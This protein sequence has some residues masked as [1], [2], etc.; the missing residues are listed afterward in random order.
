LGADRAITTMTTDPPELQA[1]SRL[2]IGVLAAPD[3]PLPQLLFDSL[4]AIFPVR[5]QPTETPDERSLDGALLVGRAVPTSADCDLPTLLVPAPSDRTGESLALSL[6]DDTRLARPLRGRGVLEDSVASHVNH[7]GSE[8]KRILATVG[9]NAVWWQSHPGERSLSVSAYPLAAPLE[10]EALRDHLRVGR[11][12]GLLPL[13]HFL[14]EQLGTRGWSPPALR[15]S[16]VIDDPNLHWHSY[17]FLK[18]P[19]LI[20]HASRHGYHVG[21][22]TVPLDGWLVNPRAASLIRENPSALSLLMHGND[23][24]SRELGRLSTEAEAERAIAQALRRVAALERRSGVRVERVMA[25]PHGACSEAALDAMF[26]LGIEAACVSR[27]YPWLD[28]LPVPTPLA[29]WDPAEIVGGGLPILPRYHLENPRED[30]VFRA[31]LGQPLILYGHH[32]DFADGLDL[33]AEAA[34]YINGLGDVRWEPLG[35]IARGNYATRQ[36]DDVLHV[37][38][39]SRRIALEVPAGVRALDIQLRE[40]LGGPRFHQM[41]HPA[42]LADLGFSEGRGRVLLEDLGESGRL[43][44]SLSADQPLGF[45]DVA[46][47]AFKAWPPARRL[48]VEVRDRSQPLLG[49]MGR[50]GSRST[51]QPV[52]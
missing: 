16:F 3:V 26:R 38:M 24:I 19:E 22:A 29:G 44:L 28:G 49:N 46:M 43:E 23:H 36:I 12:M 47:P 39:Y 33:F 51:R 27:P 42:G 40:P 21:F 52:S 45:E 8:A 2:R 20:A 50:R 32:G 48:A 31:L 18:Y 30:L 15:A 37:R 14:L 10:G 41:S 5:F 7:Q 9:A 1:D 35:Q 4:Q 25:P 11:F 6:A 13:L 17:G 34:D